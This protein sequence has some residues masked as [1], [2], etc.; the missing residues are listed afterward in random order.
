MSIH[1]D[2]LDPDRH[3][4]PA[5]EPEVYSDAWR[6]LNELYSRDKDNRDESL[7]ER[8]VY[9]YTDCGAWIQFNENGVK[10]GSIVEGSDHGANPIDL[11]WKEIPVKFTSSLQVIE[12]QCD[13]IWQ[14]ANVPRDYAGGKTDMQ[15]GLDWPL[16]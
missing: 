14:W 6:Y 12:D 7:I 5:E 2:Y 9:K 16:L 15:I 8:G 10:L 4:W 3:L 13:L 11:T 1:D